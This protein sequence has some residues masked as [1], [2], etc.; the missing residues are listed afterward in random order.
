VNALIVLAVLVFALG[1]WAGF[2]EDVGS[3]YN[4]EG[5]GDEEESD[6]DR[7]GDS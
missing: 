3:P 1:L 2:T 5:E 7:T 6:T 4:I